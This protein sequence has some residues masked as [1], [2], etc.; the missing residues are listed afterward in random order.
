[1]QFSDLGRYQVDI[2]KSVAFI[3]IVRVRDGVL[4]LPSQAEEPKVN[5]VGSACYLYKQALE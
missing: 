1:M 2:Q 5:L 4:K 3:F